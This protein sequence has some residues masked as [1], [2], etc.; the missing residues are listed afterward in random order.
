MKKFL[1]FTISLLLGL[2]LIVLICQKIDLRGVFLR[3]G[4]LTWIQILVLFLLTF[5]KI[6]VWVVRWKMILRSMGFSQLPFRNL[7]SARL[8]EIAFSHLIPGVF[9]GGELVRLFALKKNTKVPLSQGLV[10]VVSERIIE[11]ISFGIFAFFGVLILIFRQNLLGA[12]FYILI[13]AFSLIAF[14]LIF[15]LLKSEKIS[16]LIKFLHLDKIKFFSQSSAMNLVGK[17]GFICEEIINFFKNMP[18]IVFWGIILSCSGYIIDAVQIVLFVRF[19]GEPVAFANAI[20]VK[21]LIMLS[22]LVPI[23]AALGVYEGINVLAFQE[24][25]LTAETGLS[26]ALMTRLIDFSFVIVGLLIVIYYLTHHFFQISNK[27]NS[28]IN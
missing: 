5:I 28:H 9:W 13:S 3:F 6:I 27:N 1:L 10:S 12:L 16:S 11:I 4:F 23:P 26:F 21:I 17:V 14:F 18:Q 22:W 2:C 15:R 19:L 7:F 20:L 25:Q 8:G 24:F